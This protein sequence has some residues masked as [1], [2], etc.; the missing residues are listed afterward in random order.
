MQT[1]RSRAFTLIELLVVIAII[2]LL[3]GVL[4]PALGTARRSAQ[5][6]ACKVR[7]RE[8]GTA[9]LLY[10]HDNNDQTMPTNQVELE[11]GGR[12]RNWAYTFAY[13]NGPRI[14]EGYM[15]EYMQ[16]VQDS[17]S[18]PVNRREDPW[19]EYEDQAN[20]GITFLYGGDDLNFD[21]TFVGDAGGAKT[22]ADFDVRML[23]SP[24][25]G[26]P[27]QYTGAFA[28]AWINSDAFESMR[29]LPLIVEESSYWYNNNKPGV[30]V[31]DGLWG[32]L[33]EW[34]TRHG[35]PSGKGGMT[36]FQDGTVDRFVP[37]AAYENEDI[38]GTPYQTRGFNSHD[39][40]LI[41]NGGT[42]VRRLSGI[43]LGYG[44]VNDYRR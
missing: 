23:I 6:L 30:G 4:L 38:T 16:E 29:G 24:A 36:F 12:T 44:K 17:V 15:I 3:I 9:N 8:L 20:N 37:P 34:T 11:P 31:T 19:G 14:D 32:N 40:Y 22:Y 7:M 21:Y 13:Y 28:E 5:D 33:D 26:R 41:A 2:A 39:I 25:G 1:P 18:C 10:A 35:P 42:L 27:T 43:G